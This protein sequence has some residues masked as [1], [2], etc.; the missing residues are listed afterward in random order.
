MIKELKIKNNPVT[1]LI[2]RSTKILTAI[3][4]RLWEN[5]SISYISGEITMANK[6]IW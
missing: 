6:A 4:V 3:L 5:I 1:D 2:L